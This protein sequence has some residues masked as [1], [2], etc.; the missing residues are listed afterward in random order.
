MDRSWEY[1]NH[2][3]THECENWDLDRAIPRKGIH[4]WDFR[5]SVVTNGRFYSRPLIKE[6]PGGREEGKGESSTRMTPRSLVYG[7][8]NMAADGR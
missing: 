2:L 8:V 4:K 6:N 3:K 7:S 5:C 1:I